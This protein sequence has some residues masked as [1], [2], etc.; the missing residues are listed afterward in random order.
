M[1]F[2]WFQWLV[3]TETIGCVLP[4]Q[5]RIHTVN[6]DLWIL[7]FCE[8]WKGK[9]RSLTRVFWSS[10]RGLHFSGILRGLG[11]ISTI[12]NNILFPLS[13]AQQSTQHP[14]TAKTSNMPRRKSAVYV[15]QNYLYLVVSKK[16][17]VWIEKTRLFLI[18]VTKGNE[19]RVNIMTLQAACIH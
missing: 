5:W 8:L 1:C 17:K 10:V 13:K 15:C 9:K 3:H 18:T 4:F 11:W 7:S 19:I 6:F 14:R 12:R 2:L 16:K